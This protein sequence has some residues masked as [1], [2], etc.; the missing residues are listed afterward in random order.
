MKV[1]WEKAFRGALLYSLSYCLRGAKEFCFWNAILHILLSILTRKKSSAWAVIYEE[2]CNAYVHKAFKTLILEK[3][4]NLVTENELRKSWSF[5]FHL[6]LSVDHFRNDLVG[7]S[8]RCKVNLQR[9]HKFTSNLEHTFFDYFWFHSI[10]FF[11]KRRNWCQNFRQK[12]R[13]NLAH[14]SCF[15]NVDIPCCCL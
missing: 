3:L 12:N 5:S 10:F 7:F 8:L 6:L 1:W 14:T 13:N 11:A 15:Q 4:W 2:Y 9:V